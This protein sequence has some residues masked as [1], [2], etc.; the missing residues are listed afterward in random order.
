MAKTKELHFEDAIEHHLTTVGGWV[1]GKPDE[2]DRKTAL[3]AKDLF[4]FIESAQPELWGELRKHH[5]A[6][7]EAA[8]LD[9]LVKTLD[10]RG[11]LDVLR[12]G[13]KFFGKKIE[14]AYFK[15]SHGMNPDVWA[16][17][18][19]NRLVVVRQCKFAPDEDKSIDMA[20]FV[21]GFP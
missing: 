17:Y 5:Q 18:A 8:V 19:K 15:P 12:H 6:G 14:C 9:T 20:L 3:V 16:K 7:L 10:A 13:F 21:N 11:S 4:A 2:F 1:K